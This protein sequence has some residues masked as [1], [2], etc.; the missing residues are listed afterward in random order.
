MLKLGYYQCLLFPFVLLTRVLGRN[1]KAVRDAE[2]LPPA[3]LNSLFRTVIELE[4]VIGRWL[5]WPFGSSVF[6]VARKGRVDA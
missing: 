5:R 4:T 2:D 1:R 3:A 6:A